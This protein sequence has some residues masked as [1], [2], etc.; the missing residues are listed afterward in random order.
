MG[1]SPLS[2][3]PYL[4]ANSITTP[5]TKQHHGVEDEEDLRLGPRLMT[6]RLHHR[7]LGATNCFEPLWTASRKLQPS[8]VAL[9]EPTAHPDLLSNSI[10][11]GESTSRAVCR[12]NQAAALRLARADP[13]NYTTNAMIR[14]C[15]ALHLQL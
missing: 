15:D 10:H 12:G 5:L 8:H 4:S 7:S 11:P 14:V 6:P 3:G 9:G 13:P 1:P 2:S